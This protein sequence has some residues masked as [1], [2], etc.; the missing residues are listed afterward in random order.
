ML[1][2]EQEKDFLKALV[3][4]A[5][6]RF[7]AGMAPTEEIDKQW[8]Q[9]L[10]HEETIQ[11]LANEKAEIERLMSNGHAQTH[12]EPRPNAYIPEDLGIPRPFGAGAFKPT[13]AGATMRHTKKPKLP[14][15]VI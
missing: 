14:D 9:I 1:D 3:E 5:K 15:V 4:D 10:R 8:D 11:K 6:M 7:T 2:L 13:P 12:C